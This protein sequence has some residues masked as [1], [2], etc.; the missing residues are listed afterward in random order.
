MSHTP[1]SP[2]PSGSRS[3]PATPDASRKE[4]AETDAAREER[5]G[6]KMAGIGMQTT[7]EVAAG[8]LIGWLVDWWR[9]AGHTG[10]MVGGIAGIA[11]AMWT[12]ISRALKL[13]KELD[14]NRTRRLP[15]PLPEST[16]NEPDDDRDADDSET[17]HHG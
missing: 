1:L 7:S 14:R 8:L 9:G 13:N 11:V 15:P 12:L 10:V 3:N 17:K 6:W 16:W 2:D 5:V 4:A